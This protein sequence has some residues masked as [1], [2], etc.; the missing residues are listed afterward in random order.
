[1]A[2]GGFFGQFRHAL[3]EKGR[4]SVPARFRAVIE[5]EADGGHGG[6]YVTLGLD[7]CLF[8]YSSRRWAEV[9][10]AVQDGGGHPF[11]S[12]D[13]RRFQRQFFASASFCEPDTQGRILIPEPLRAA[14]GF[15]H[16]VVFVGVMDRIEL[17]DAGRWTREEAE[18]RSGYEHAA[19]AALE[20]PDRGDGAEAHGGGRAGR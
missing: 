2:T 11:A 3:D 18:G 7:G 8:A 5:A 20:G 19:E 12:R 14:A 1:M 4:V 16:E 13:K 6:L 10:A 9:E 15:T 17:W